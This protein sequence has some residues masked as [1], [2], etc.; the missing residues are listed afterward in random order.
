[1]TD[2][3]GTA[4]GDERISKSE[5]V[6]DALLRLIARADAAGETRLPN[7]RELAEQIGTGRPA[8]REGLS[9]LESLQML[10]PR[11]GS[12]LY[13]V[14][15]HRRSPEALV[16]TEHA[17][18]L[19]ESAVNEAMA[20]RALLETEVVRLATLH[21]ERECL[22]RMEVEIERLEAN[23]GLGHDAA[24]ADQE[25]HRAMAAASG[26]GTLARFVD[27]FLRMSWRR[28]LQY[29]ANAQRS[30]RSVDEHR[31]LLAAIRSGD[32]ERARAAIEIHLGSAERFWAA[33]AAKDEAGR[34]G[35][36]HDQRAA[37]RSINAPR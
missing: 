1:M 26:N 18:P 3:D 8:I 10:M 27:L 13:I 24:L 35:D 6:L 37:S 19:P 29:F 21:R 25:F 12:G 30:R 9:K 16:L 4:P 7:E 32:S 31:L 22:H 11:Q 15:P 23:I 28:R 33:A 14:P 2:T 5:R 34:P 20:V 36:Q 17:T